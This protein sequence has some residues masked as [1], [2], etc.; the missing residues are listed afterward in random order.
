[1]AFFPWFAS[2]PAFDLAAWR[3]TVEAH[4]WWLTRLGEL[5]PATV[6]GTRPVERG[7]RRLDEAFAWSASGGY[8]GMHVKAFLPREEVL[9]IGLV[10]ARRGH[11]RAS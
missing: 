8:R 9:G 5:S 4:D 10:P 7:G 1:M 6:L 3:R 2:V 11:L